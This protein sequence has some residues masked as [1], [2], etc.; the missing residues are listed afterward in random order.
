MF[1][2]EKG[3]KEI[4]SPEI[5]KKHKLTYVKAVAA[6]YAKTGMKAHYKCS[7]GK[8][9]TDVNCKNETNKAKL[10]V[11]KLTV[12]KT[13]IKKVTAKSKALKISWKKKNGVTGYEVQVALKKNFKTG[14]KK[15]TLK[16]AGKTSVT[17]KKLKS[18]KDYYIRV[19]A[20]KKV[21]G[22]KYYSK[23]SSVNRKKTK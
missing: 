23:W 11:N 20:Y 18:K 6:T 7:C 8:L 12:P 14:L 9:Y 16:G 2:D 19:R 5:I 13:S 21:G 4:A 15:A 3:T 10:I 22:K 1:S 17:V